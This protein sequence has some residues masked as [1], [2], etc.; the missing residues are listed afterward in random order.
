[1]TVHRLFVDDPWA[2]YIQ[3]GQKRIEG[4]LNKDKYK[5]FEVDDLILWNNKFYSKIKALRRYPSFY[6]Y[7]FSEN[8]EE[9]LP[10]VKSVAE[11]VNDVY[12]KYYLE[13]EEKKYGVLCIELTSVREIV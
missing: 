3:S 6:C 1:M 9:C 5:Q 13:E 12:Y 7:L 2:E 11:G 4:R 10:G 8:L